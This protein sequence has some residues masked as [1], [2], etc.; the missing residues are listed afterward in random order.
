LL[1]RL[2]LRFVLAGHLLLVAGALLLFRAF[3]RGPLLCRDMLLL[4]ALRVAFPG[5]HLLLATLLLGALL[6]LLRVS[7]ICTGFVGAGFIL[8][9]VVCASLVLASLAC[10][11]LA[12][13][14]LALASFAGTRLIGAGFVCAR[15]IRAS[16]IRTSLVPPLLLR[17]LL[18]LGARLRSSLRRWT[19][20]LCVSLF[21]LF[22]V[23]RGRRHCGSQH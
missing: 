16:L 20:G 17:M 5:C 13:A 3:C 15:L 10:A 21:S 12:C 4:V 14:S 11:S 23:L 19:A 8:A 9:S 7:L 18:A 22:L 6:L 1:L 2:L